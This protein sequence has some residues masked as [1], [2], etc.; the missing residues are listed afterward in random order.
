MYAS[1][2]IQFQ[3]QHHYHSHIALVTIFVPLYSRFNAFPFIYYCWICCVCMW[4]MFLIASDIP[5]QKFRKKSAFGGTPDV[6]VSALIR[7]S[8]PSS[9]DFY[10][11]CSLID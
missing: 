2:L 6:S 11:I 8:S 9:F 5:S 10:K 1:H 3:T 7:N 4:L